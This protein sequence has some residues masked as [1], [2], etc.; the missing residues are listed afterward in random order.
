MI[1]LALLEIDR[2]SESEIRLIY[3]ND[4]V[5]ACWEGEQMGIVNGLE[6]KRD[7]LEKEELAYI[8]GGSQIARLGI[9]PSVQVVDILENHPGELLFGL[10]DRLLQE[11]MKGKK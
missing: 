3:S 10:I 1:R 8:I 7:K 5:P 11:V 9:G 4:G 2:L 6:Q